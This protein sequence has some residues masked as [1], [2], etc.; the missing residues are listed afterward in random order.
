MAL[1]IESGLVL[2]FAF[3]DI[4]ERRLGTS[5]IGVGADAEDDLVWEVKEEMLAFSS[6]AVER[7]REVSLLWSGDFSLKQFTHVAVF[8]DP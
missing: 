4:K 7:L 2:D 6:D 8:Y 5:V 3:S 1:G